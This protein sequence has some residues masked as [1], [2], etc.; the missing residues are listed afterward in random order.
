MYSD[1][2]YHQNAYSILLDFMKGYA[3]FNS[4]SAN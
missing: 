4:K 3:R 1:E 2:N